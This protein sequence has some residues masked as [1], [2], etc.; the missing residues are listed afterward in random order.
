MVR[1]ERKAVPGRR[2]TGLDSVSFSV[3]PGARRSDEQ[4][5]VPDGT[6]PTF[7][8]SPGAAIAAPPETIAYVAAFDPAGSRRDA[9]AVI[10][11]ASWDDIFYPDGVGAWMA[12]VDADTGSGAELPSTRA[13]FRTATTSVGCGCTRPAY[14]AAPRATPTALSNSRRNGGSHAGLRVERST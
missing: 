8:R 13:S 9:M 10:D 6:D 1:P 12:R 4:L 3:G 7:Y 5:S 11:Y 14:R 2:A